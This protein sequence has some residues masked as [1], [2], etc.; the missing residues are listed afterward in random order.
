VELP[1][2]EFLHTLSAS[3]PSLKYLEIEC[4]NLERL[5]QLDLKKRKP[6]YRINMPD[7]SFDTISLTSIDSRLLTFTLLQC[8]R[9][10]MV[11]NRGD[12]FSILREHLSQSTLSENIKAL[13]Q[14]LQL[15]EY[16]ILLLNADT[17]SSLLFHLAK[18]KL[19]Q[20]YSGSK[21]NAQNG[22]A[23]INL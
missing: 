14:D 5:G 23:Y 13:L 21:N 12:V 8:I 11:W 18:M 20:W 10:M 7:I 2:E 6:F 16:F 17:S 22:L 19:E 4:I 15:V 1:D 9:I 3:L